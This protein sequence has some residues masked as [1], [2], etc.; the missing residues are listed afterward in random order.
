MNGRKREYVVPLKW[1]VMRKRL[2]LEGDDMPET[3]VKLREAVQELEDKGPRVS[4]WDNF[5]VLAREVFR[6]KGFT[7]THH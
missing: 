4:T 7:E 1:G 5:L 3:G 6:D 2:F